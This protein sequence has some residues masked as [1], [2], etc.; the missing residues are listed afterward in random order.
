MA[1]E[2]LQKVLARAGIA[3]RRAA[4]ELIVQGHVRVN[5]R[6]VRELGTKA[7]PRKDRIEVDGERVTTELPVYVVLHKPRGVVST[8]NDPEGRPTVGELLRE[9][10]GRAYPIGRLDFATSGVL[11]ATNDGA[12]ADGLMH[13][14]RAVPKTYVVKVKGLMKPADIDR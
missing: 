8:M 14:R 10:P 13:P 1:T 4:E 5:G 2:R 11:L 6:V 9:V 12:F 7:D 3:S